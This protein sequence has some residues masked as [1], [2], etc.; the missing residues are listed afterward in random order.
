[1]TNTVDTY[2]LITIQRALCKSTEYYKRN[3]LKNIFC[4]QLFTSPRFINTKESRKKNE[5]FTVRL[6][7]SV[8]PRPPFLR[9]AF[10]DLFLCVLLTLYYDY[11][12]SETDFTQEKVNFYPTTRIPNSSSYCC[13]PPADRL[14]GAGPSF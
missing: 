1:M 8:D 5:H 14:Q 4:Q 3:I 12:C 6:T 11:I 10:C 13:C 7:E 2:P 9:S